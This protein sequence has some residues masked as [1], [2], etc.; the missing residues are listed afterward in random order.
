MRPVVNKPTPSLET[1]RA[2]IE[3]VRGQMAE[4]AARSG[5]ELADIEL[6][7]VSKTVSSEAVLRLASFPD[8]FACH[9]FGENRVDELLRKRTDCPDETFHLIGTLQTNK[10]KLVVG[11][12]ALIHSVDSVHLL[13]T[14]NER[15]ALRGVVQPVLIQVNASGEESKHGFS[16]QDLLPILDHAQ[17]LD[18]V[19][20]NG[21]MTM[22]PFDAPD[23]VRWVF[24]EVRNLRD[25]LQGQFS[26]AVQLH[27]LSMGMTN[28]F[29]VA[30][31]E[32]STLIR[33][34]TA[35]FT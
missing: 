27:H 20:V 14:I 21:L 19:L 16:P 33:V 2:N 3:R 12:V 25:R 26:G 5:R 18:S 23:S 6:I 32:G 4:A 29:E 34:G 9:V 31:E 8:N 7:A 13:D 15:A 22:A 30:I 1:L 35:L 10:A 11:E 28:D 17:G 24:N